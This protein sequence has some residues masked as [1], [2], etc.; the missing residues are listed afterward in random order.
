MK[1]YRGITILHTLL[2][3]WISLS[4][5]KLPS[6]FQA[7][8][9]TSM[10]YCCP[11]IT[12]MNSPFQLWKIFTIQQLTALPK[13]N[14]PHLVLAV[15]GASHP[16]PALTL[17]PINAN[18]RT[19]SNS[20]NSVSYCSTASP[21][22]QLTKVKSLTAPITGESPYSTSL[23]NYLAEFCSKKISPRASVAS[24]PTETRWTWCVSSV[25]S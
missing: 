12:P 14:H 8:Y 9:F 16:P 3:P 21:I 1:S 22:F 10:Q 19:V 18:S 20:S 13:P 7:P 2:S 4:F 23:A 17:S 6:L 5:I 24:E 15:T 25:N 11:Y